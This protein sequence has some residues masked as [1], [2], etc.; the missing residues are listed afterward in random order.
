MD[1]TYIWIVGVGSRPTSI[2]SQPEASR[3]QVTAC[4]SI[5]PLD[6]LSRPTTTRPVPTYEPNAC[7]KAHAN[8]G[9]RKSPTTPRIPDMPILSRCSLTPLVL[10]FAASPR[11]R[12]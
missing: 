4:C 3:P 5:G 11:L 9:V 12:L 10:P 1:A 7:A 8:A 2:A 6:L